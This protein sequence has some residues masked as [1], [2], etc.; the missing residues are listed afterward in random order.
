MKSGFVALIGRPNAGKSTLLNALV[1]QK[2]AII[3]PKPQTTRNSIRAIRTDDDS[4]IIFVDTPGIHK[5]K[6]ELG[7][8][9]NKEAYSA[10]AGVD[11]IYYL[12]DG[13][14]PFG[15][16][17]EFVLNTLRQMHLPVYL[18]LNKI[19]LLEKEQLIELLLQWQKRMDFK[20][21][22]PIS[23]KTQNNL[24]QLIEVTKN[25]LTD[26]V[27]YYPADQV[28]DYPEQFI[29]AEIIR[30][31]VLMLTEEE[32][33]HSVAVVIERIRK[34]REHLIIH[35]MILVERDSQKG[36]IIGKQGRM[37]KQIGMLAREELQG[38]LGE[39]IFLELFVR[40]EKDWRNKRAKLQQLGY[41]QTELEDE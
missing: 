32:V 7:T 18:I 41:I 25:D 1:Q 36:I 24:D 23:A 28:C 40:V 20:E 3:S 38:L 39:P 10:A 27:Q 35:A 4:Q 37:I 11:L 13:S 14:V 26:G 15:S 21:I 8:Q 31:K 2:V 5:P 12:V 29:M 17:D 33:P 34:N 6:H 30:E 19:D 9:M 16:G 22:I